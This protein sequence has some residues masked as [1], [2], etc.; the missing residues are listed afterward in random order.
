MQ[1]PLV[2]RAQGLATAR[3]LT[4]H[5]INVDFAPVLDVNH[6]GFI[7]PRTFGPTAAEVSSRGVAFLQGLAQGGVAATVKHFPGLGYAQNSTDGGPVTVD[8]PADK[9]YADLATFQAAVAAKAPLVMISTAIYPALRD[10]VPAATSPQIVETLLRGKL[11]YR[12]VV[13]SD[14]LDTPGVSPFYAPGRAAVKA[15][16]AGV[17]LALEPGA[18]SSHPLDDADSAYRRAPGR[19]SIGGASPLTDPRRLQARA[20]TEAKH[21]MATPS[22]K[23]HRPNV[24]LRTRDEASSLSVMRVRFNRPPPATER[25]VPRRGGARRRNAR[26]G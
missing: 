21:L 17:D 15:L 13:I 5:G 24:R 18:A 20:R 26:L 23:P 12:G 16:A 19:R 2:A 10:S 8:A 11:G 6:G 3:N 14:S 1:S 7:G 4:A 9:L 25:F 22:A